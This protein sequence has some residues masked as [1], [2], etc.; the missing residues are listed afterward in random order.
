MY[1]SVD[2]SYVIGFN[3]MEVPTINPVS[4]SNGIG[5]Y[6]IVLIGS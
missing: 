4:Y 2:T 3:G 1:V 5:E 6:L